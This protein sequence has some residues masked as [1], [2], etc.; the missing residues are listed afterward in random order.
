[1]KFMQLAIWLVLIK[2]SIPTLCVAGDRVRLKSASFTHR[3]NFV[4]VTFRGGARH[5]FNWWSFSKNIYFQIF[6]APER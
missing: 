5:K 1:M 4:A 2:H 3:G 6:I